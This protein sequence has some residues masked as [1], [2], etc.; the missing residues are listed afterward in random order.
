MRNLVSIQSNQIAKII[1]SP[2]IINYKSQIENCKDL[3]KTKTH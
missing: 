1:L 3:V 2:T